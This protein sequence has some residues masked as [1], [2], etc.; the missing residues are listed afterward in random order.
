[1]GTLME[2]NSQESVDLI[3]RARAG[4]R[5]AINALLSCSHRRPALPMR[6]LNWPPAPTARKT[7]P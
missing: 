4:D 3:E 6:L 7:L 2:N 5:D 1:M